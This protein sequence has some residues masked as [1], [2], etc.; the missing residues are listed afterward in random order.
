M[1]KN[2]GFLAFLITLSV[3]CGCDTIDCTLYNTVEMR[4]NFYMN[5]NSAQLDDT[6]TITAIDTNIVLLNRK[7]MVSGVELSLSYF[8]TED[9]L[10][11]TVNG[12]DY[13]V[14]DTLWIEK[15]S[16]SHFESPDCPV[17]MFHDITAVRCTHLFIDSV[18]IT[19]PDV[20]FSDHENLQIH[21]YPS[22]D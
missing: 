18:T 14:S 16:Y 4:C 15:T 5:G 1:Q 13:E 7:N 11:L 6:L 12:K 22:A 19:H 9:T 10:I 3:F 20:N 2:K 17:N 8:N 21:F